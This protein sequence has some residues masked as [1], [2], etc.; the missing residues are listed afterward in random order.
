MQEEAKASYSVPGLCAKPLQLCWAIR[1]Q[2]GVIYSSIWQLF[3][4]KKDQKKQEGVTCLVPTARHTKWNTFWWAAGLIRWPETWVGEWILMLARSSNIQ[5]FAEMG[6][7]VETVDN[8]SWVYWQPWC[9]SFFFQWNIDEIVIFSSHSLASF[10]PPFTLP[11]CHS[12]SDQPAFLPP[13]PRFL[14]CASPRPRH[15]L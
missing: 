7:E 2:L 4:A 12:A 10:P 5:L 14:I 13:H 9:S 1:T 15:S 8:I 3:P 11:V 6:L